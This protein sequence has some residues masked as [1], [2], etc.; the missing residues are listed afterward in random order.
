[1]KTQYISLKRPLHNLSNQD[2]LLSIIALLLTLLPLWIAGAV[3][4]V[5]LFFWL[6]PESDETLLKRTLQGYYVNINTTE[7]QNKWQKLVILN[8]VYMTDALTPQ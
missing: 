5:I 3:M 8:K 7:D 1:M 6:N 2:V 4:L